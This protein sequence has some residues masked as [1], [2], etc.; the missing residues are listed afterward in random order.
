M[1][2]NEKIYVLDVNGEPLEPT[3]RNGHVRRLLKENKA[4][5]V[6]RNPFT[7]QLLEESNMKTIIVSSKP[8]KAVKADLKLPIND[9]LRNASDFDGF[10]VYLDVDELT[11]ETYKQ[12]KALPYNYKLMFYRDNSASFIKE[13]IITLNN[14]Q[15]MVIEKSPIKLSKD[16]KM[17]G[18]II[19]CGA[20][21]SGKTAL[22]KTIAQQ[23]EDM[24]A[25]VEYLSA[26]HY[27]YNETKG[28]KPVAEKFKEYNNEMMTRFKKME[29]QGVNNYTKLNDPSIKVKVLVVDDFDMITISEDYKSVD[30]IKN[31][32][33]GLARCSKATGLLFIL[34]CQETGKGVFTNAL[35]NTTSN[36]ILLG[37]VINEE[38][39]ASL[40]TNDIVLDGKVLNPKAIKLAGFCGVVGSLDYCDENGLQI[41]RQFKLS[42]VPEYLN[43]IQE[44]P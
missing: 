16:I 28:I 38:T 40:F 29:E 31:A 23:Y 44:N 14:E 4:K 21:G 3:N 10:M 12:I 9:F 24:G 7:I 30:V 19:I 11:E 27:L 13:E 32:L 2:E 5:V 41:I 33:Y 34:T 25:S 22:A 20:P 15:T 17:N 1:N 43:T 26:T 18:N 36:K 6:K 35:I 39:P 42:D 8:T 37:P